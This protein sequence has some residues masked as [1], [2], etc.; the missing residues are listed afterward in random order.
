MNIVRSNQELTWMKKLGDLFDIL[1][2]VNEGLDVWEIIGVFSLNLLEQ[3]YNKES[4]GSYRDDGLSIF[5]K[6]RSPQ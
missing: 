2:D 4:D 1:M 6:W 5:K 3:Q